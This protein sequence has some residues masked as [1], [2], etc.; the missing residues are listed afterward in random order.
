MR[1]RDLLARCGRRGGPGVLAL[2]GADPAAR[3]DL[4]LNIAD[5]YS[6]AHWA[7]FLSGGLSD[8]VQAAH[9]D[10]IRALFPKAR[11]ARL[12]KA[13]HWLHAE[14]PRAFEATVRAFLNAR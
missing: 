9:R 5:T 14:E 2:R 4:L 1:R 7:L 12:P 11:F 10:R 6:Y 3:A 8:Y 13:G